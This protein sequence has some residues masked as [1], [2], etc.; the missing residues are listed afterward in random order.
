MPRTVKKFCSI[1]QWLQKVDRSLYDVVDALC[2]HRLLVPA[3]NTTGVTFLYPT[4][5]KYK[6]T[7]FDAAYGDNPEMAVQILKS[8]VVKSYL[9]K[10]SDFLAQRDDIPNKLGQKIE[11]AAADSK[12]VTLATGSKLTLPDK[13]KAFDARGDRANMAVYLMS[14]GKPIPLNGKPSEGK[15][16]NGKSAPKKG[17]ALLIGW[18]TSPSD[19][20]VMDTADQLAMGRRGNR[21]AERVLSFFRWAKAKGLLEQYAVCLRPFA[22]LSYACLMALWQENSEHFA[23]WLTETKGLYFSNDADIHKEYAKMYTDWGGD[24][25]S[26][27]D[28]DARA[29]ARATAAQSNRLEFKDEMAKLYEGK[30]PLT[31][32]MDMFCLANHE[33][34]NELLIAEQAN[35]ANDQQAT[36]LAIQLATSSIE[37]QVVGGRNITDVTRHLSGGIAL[38][39]STYGGYWPLGGSGKYGVGGEAHG[40]FVGDVLTEEGYPSVKPFNMVGGHYEM[41]S[42]RS[43]PAALPKEF[44]ANLMD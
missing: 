19:M 18:E 15:Y 41:Q 2:L 17:G 20:R 3:H 9:P 26:V 4:D 21:F 1:N 7:I 38:A 5:A 12:S 44:V 35:G 43:A 10:T 23:Q 8:L 22:E 11:I 29:T 33:L 25:E 13:A 32:S 14:G 24:L 30:H 37:S 31:M 39:R 34:M 40:P 28:H 16:A 36:A 27:A 6:K 42:E